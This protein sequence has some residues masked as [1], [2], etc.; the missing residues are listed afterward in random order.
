MAP[1]PRRSLDAR[2]AVALHRRGAA[3]DDTIGVG[4]VTTALALFV[5]VGIRRG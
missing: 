1:R 4:M 2:V 3:L 5:A